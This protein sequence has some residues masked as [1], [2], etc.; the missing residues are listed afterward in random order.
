MINLSLPLLDKN[1][2]QSRISRAQKLMGEKNIDYLIV[3]VGTD[4]YYLTGYEKKPS[5]RITC[6]VI[7]SNGGPSMITSFFE[8]AKLDKLD[9]FYPILTWQETDN[10]MDLF[11]GIIDPNTNS[12]VAVDERSWAIFLL[13][14]QKALPKSDWVSG[15]LVTAPL[16]MLKDDYEVESLRE[17]GRRVD[18]LYEEMVKP[19]VIKFTGKTENEVG[20]QI[21]DLSKEFDMNAAKSAG[22]A[23][24]A[25]GHS[26]HHANTDY[27]IQPGDGIWMEIGCG[28]HYNGYRIDKTR[29]V[30]VGPAT[31]KFAKIY[32]IVD[33]AQQAA[34]LQVKPGVT[35]ESI[36]DAART[37]ITKSG[38]GEYF[39]HR[40]GHGLGL[41]GH[42][43]PYMVGGNK[44]PL[45]KGMSFSD[46]PGIYLPG[47]FGIRI[48]DTL[49]CTDNGAE[50]MFNST[51]DLFIVK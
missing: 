31:D 24:G 25:N 13:R 48:E 47:E 49:V 8:A 39:T 19:G 51:H 27:V 35:C 16:R 11:S 20:A 15:N 45:Q 2:S 14:M 1:V 41:D 4:M 29:S 3:H 17:G 40:V 44:L 22:I 12:T 21:F 18:K 28:G 36:D 23:A 34:F 32:K 30:Q 50:R 33:D 5:E 26:P 9:T 42:E 43:E 6:F 38:Y 37:L 10:P 7:P 46:E